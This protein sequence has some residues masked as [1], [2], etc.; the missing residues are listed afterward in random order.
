MTKREKEVSD[1]PIVLSLAEF[2]FWIVVKGWRR[3]A[4]AKEAKTASPQHGGRDWDELKL[5]I[6]K[7]QPY[8]RRSGADRR[9]AEPG[10]AWGIGFDIIIAV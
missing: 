4:R 7:C 9:Y 2:R 3:M 8:R 5:T 10:S 1:K 6:E